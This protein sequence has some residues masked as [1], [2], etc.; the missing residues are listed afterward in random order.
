M[1]RRALSLLTLLL[2]LLLTACGGSSPNYRILPLDVP[3]TLQVGDTARLT[4]DERSEVV[5]SILEDTRAQGGTAR[6]RVELREG[7]VD[8]PITGDV[9]LP[10]VV[11]VELGR[12]VET[13]PQWLRPLYRI[14]FVSLSPETAPQNGGRYSLTLQF[15]RKVIQ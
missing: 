8:Q 13:E 9:R 6:A 1:T 3:V 2:P 15:Q 12:T 7:P 11:T 5:V 14:Q 10:D 4:G